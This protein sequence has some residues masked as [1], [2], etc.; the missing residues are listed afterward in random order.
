MTKEWVKSIG[1][2]LRQHGEAGDVRLALGELLMTGRP[3]EGLTNFLGGKLTPRVSL[4][5]RS[6][7][8]DGLTLLVRGQTLGRW[9]STVLS[10]L[11]SIRQTCY[12]EL[13]PATERVLLLLKELHGWSLWSVLQPLLPAV[14]LTDVAFVCARCRPQKYSAHL[15]LHADDISKSISV[16]TLLLRHLIKLEQLARDEHHRFT[17][18]CFWLAYGAFLRLSGPP[19]CS[20]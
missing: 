6:D 9:E 2:A 1:D 8:I 13:V 11:T 12:A 14:V 5:E 7:A 15:N 10:A 18:F 16:T 3:G 19:G 20:A 4:L 17:H